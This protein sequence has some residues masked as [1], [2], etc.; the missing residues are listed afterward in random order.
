MRPRAPA[1]APP[2]VVAWLALLASLPLPAGG[3]LAAAPTHGSARAGAVAVAAC[4]APAAA[5]AI[6]GA[7]P[8]EPVPPPVM[9]SAFSLA[10]P[11][12]DDEE[13]L[14]ARGMGRAKEKPDAEKRARPRRIGKAPGALS[15]ERAR[16]M[17]QSLTVP[18]WGQ[19]TLGQRRSAVAFALL[20]VGVW[21]SFTAFRIQQQMRR[22]TYERTARLF[23]GIDLSERDEEFRR[24]VGFYLSSDEY[25]RLVVRR[26]AA[27]LYFGD[28]AAYDA[29]IA[30][31]ELKGVDTWSWNSEQDLERYR[32]ERQS[33]QR[34]TKHAEDALVAAVINRLLSAIHASRSGARG[35]AGQRAWK[36]QCVPVAGDPTAF[37]LGLRT[38]F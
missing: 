2:A 22:E 5:R 17:L 16:L 19:A 35:A 26:D 3:A 28:P 25:N 33:A 36:V 1:F 8:L 34:A 32:T 20:E 21:G 9:G 38:D 27:N 31:H 30:A 29:Y 11:L 13:L 37:R 12:V 7:E 4:P 10:S 14:A 24:T 18:G 6:F 23:G 15:G